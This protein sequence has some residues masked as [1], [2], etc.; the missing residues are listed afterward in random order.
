MVSVVTFHL[1]NG[2]L[3]NVENNRAVAPSGAVVRLTPSL[4]VQHFGVGGERTNRA[5]IGLGG[6][7]PYQEVAG[8]NEHDQYKQN[9]YQDDHVPG[10]SAPRRAVP[11]MQ[12]YTVCPPPSGGA[13]L[14]VFRLGDR[15]IRHRAIPAKYGEG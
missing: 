5:G 14:L 6:A 1:I 13:R 8:P 9:G 12:D 10:D 15:A 2:R 7:I 3:S 11:P 4:L